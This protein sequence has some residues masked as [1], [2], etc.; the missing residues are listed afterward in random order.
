ML[1]T[2]VTLIN[3]LV[4][5]STDINLKLCRQCENIIFLVIGHFGGL[6]YIKWK[7][8]RKNK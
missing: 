3:D 6:I 2:L 4:F 7:V 5:N 8:P 1:N